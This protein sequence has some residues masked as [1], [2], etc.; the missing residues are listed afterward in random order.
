M[1]TWKFT[2]DDD[3]DTIIVTNDSLGEI[4]HAVAAWLSEKYGKPIKPHRVRRFGVW[5]RVT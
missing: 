2:T 4:L 5:S 1:A 3:G